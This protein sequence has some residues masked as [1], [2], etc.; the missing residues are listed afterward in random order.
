[1]GNFVYLGC[2][3]LLF[4]T[5]LGSANPVPGTIEVVMRLTNGCYVLAM[6]GLV[7]CDMAFGEDGPA[8]DP[9]WRAKAST[10][11]KA[12]YD[13]YKALSQR[14]EEVSELRYAKAPGPARTLPFT[15]H[16]RRD[17]TIRLD[18]NMIW[19][20]LR[21]DDDSPDRPQILLRCD[22]SDY[23]FTLAKARED[24]PYALANYTPGKRQVSLVDQGLAVHAEAYAHLRNL[25]SAVG[26]EGKRTLQILRFDEARGLLQ[27][28]FTISTQDDVIKDQLYV[29]SGHEWRVVEH[30][31]ETR[32]AV[33]KSQWT[34]G[35]SVGGLTFPAGFKSVMT[36]KVDNAPPNMSITAKLI[37]LKLTDKTPDDFRLSAFGLPE[38]ADVVP[39]VK[40][41]RGAL[42]GPGR[43]LR[44]S[45]A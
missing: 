18:D 7:S 4:L 45:A 24:S 16:T 13:R 23:H 40:P 33:G 43:A 27:T 5:A 10:E 28:E 44:A 38:P 42:A 22:N 9:A 34:Y 8:I 37:S 35:E 2:A 19:E 31:L 3:V 25:L 1:V 41:T 6:A 30:L 32:S 11:I 29:G 36:C 21:T 39:P 26:N 14:L 12:V 15:P 20:Q 17:R